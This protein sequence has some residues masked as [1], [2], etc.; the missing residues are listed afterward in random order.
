V[1]DLRRRFPSA[2]RIARGALQAFPG[3]RRVFAVARGRVRAVAVAAP[4]ALDDPAALAAALREA[5]R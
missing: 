4:R 1:S 2:R 5:R 3:S